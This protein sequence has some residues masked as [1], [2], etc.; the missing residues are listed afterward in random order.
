MHEMIIHLS[1]R[2]VD[3]DQDLLETIGRFQR[4]LAD[5]TGGFFVHKVTFAWSSEDKGKLCSTI[6]MRYT[7]VFRDDLNVD[8]VKIAIR[9]WG[10]ELKEDAVYCVIR[11]EVLIIDCTSSAWTKKV[12]TTKH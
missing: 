11:G 7:A 6:M 5:L 12:G 2:G 8:G 9:A 1:P 10:V 4:W 3:D